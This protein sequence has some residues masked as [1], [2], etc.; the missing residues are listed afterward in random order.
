MRLRCK[1][2]IKLIFSFKTHMQLW[3][4]HCDQDDGLDNIFQMA[5]YALLLL[6]HVETFSQMEAHTGTHTRLLNPGPAP[7]ETW[8]E[9]LQLNLKVKGGCE[10]VSTVYAGAFFEDYTAVIHIVTLTRWPAVS[11]SLLRA[12]SLER[13]CS[14][15]WNIV[16]CGLVCV[17]NSPQWEEW[18]WFWFFYSMSSTQIF[19]W[20]LV[21]SFRSG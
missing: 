2:L 5:H 8:S 4:A 20:T 10:N 15:L 18:G 9:R 17:M 14:V 1:K 7:L 21:C 6:L 16:T 3:A 19:G 11:G 12:C 13:S